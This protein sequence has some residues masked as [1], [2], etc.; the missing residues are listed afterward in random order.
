VKK[1]C[2]CPNHTRRRDEIQAVEEYLEFFGSALV[3][4]GSFFGC[5]DAF[6]QDANALDNLEQLWSDLADESLA[7]QIAQESDIGAKRLICQQLLGAISH[8]NSS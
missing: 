1:S 7:E 3:R 4:L 6:G 8:V 5:S 2:K